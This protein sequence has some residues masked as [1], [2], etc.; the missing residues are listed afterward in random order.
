MTVRERLRIKEKRADCSAPSLSASL[1][2]R[3]RAT[4][5]PRADPDRKRG[6]KRARGRAAAKRQPSEV[7]IL[8]TEGDLRPIIVVQRGPAVEQIENIRQHRHAPPRAELEVVIRMQI[9]RRLYGSPA[10]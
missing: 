10:S 5:V 1:W 7:R 4:I 3:S 9:N 8:H 2:S 6:L